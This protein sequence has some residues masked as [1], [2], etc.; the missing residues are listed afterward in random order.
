MN[1]Q[2]SKARRKRF[3]KAFLCVFMSLWFALILW[4]ATATV[5]PD[6]DNATGGWSTTPLWE[7]IDEDIDS[8]DGSVITS[9]NDPAVTNEINFTVTCPADVGTITS[10]T[11]R[12]RARK[13][14]AGGRNIALSTVSWTGAG[15]LQNPD[16]A[17]D[18][19][20]MSEN[21]TNFASAS[22]PVSVTKAQ[23]DASLMAIVPETTGTGPGR[24]A[25]VDTFNLD[26]V[27]DAAGGG[28]KRV[29]IALRGFQR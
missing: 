2:G 21:L 24:A 1:H 23:C 29:V 4:A 19:G 20:I 14:A 13:S 7:N 9:P 8:P 18:T 10:A 25:V 28:R 17:F 6:G 5:A 27:Y 11:L 22:T 26:I 16:I 15:T 3:I 12:V